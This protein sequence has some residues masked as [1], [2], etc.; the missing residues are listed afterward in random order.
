MAAE[1]VDGAWLQTSTVAGA[2]VTS[3]DHGCGQQ[4]APNGGASNDATRAARRSTQPVA[5][6][7]AR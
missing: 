6:R 1:G 2:A 3:G 4:Q 5:K 7:A